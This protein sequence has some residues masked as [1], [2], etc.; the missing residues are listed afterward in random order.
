[1]NTL[2]PSAGASYPIAKPFHV[3]DRDQEGR[4]HLFSEIK[5]NTVIV[6]QTLDQV[7]RH[8]NQSARTLPPVYHQQRSDD[9]RGLG[10]GVLLIACGFFIQ[11][12]VFTQGFWDVAPYLIMG[13]GFY[14]ALRHYIVS[15]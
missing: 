6:E 4:Y 2:N 13:I 8:R 5:N 1:M 14:I 9:Y 15:T 7:Q 3:T 12:F 10:L 11:A